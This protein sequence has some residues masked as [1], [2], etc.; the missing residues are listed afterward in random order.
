MH[1][2]ICSC[3]LTTSFYLDLLGEQELEL[4]RDEDEDKR[5]NN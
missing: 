2:I 1:A 3:N 4:E 5:Q